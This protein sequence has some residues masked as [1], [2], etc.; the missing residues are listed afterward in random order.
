MHISKCYLLE[1]DAILCLGSYSEESVAISDCAA[2]CINLV[3]SE[4]GGN[5]ALTSFTLKTEGTLH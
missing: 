1:Q 5:P 4:D 3:Y 2:L